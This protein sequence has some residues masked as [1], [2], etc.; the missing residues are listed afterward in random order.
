MNKFFVFVFLFLFSIFIFSHDK[1]FRFFV[2]NNENN[3]SNSSVNDSLED[4]KGF[5]WFA[6][7]N[8]LNKW[9]GN[10]MTVYKKAN[11]DNSVSGNFINNLIKC[12]HGNI[13]I[14]TMDKGIS[15]YDPIK[16]HFRYYSVENGKLPDDNVTFMTLNKNTNI[17]WIVIKNHGLFYFDKDTD[18]FINVVFLNDINSVA[19]RE[20]EVWLGTNSGIKIYNDGK[21]R[22]FDLLNGYKINDIC[23]ECE[24]FYFATD[25]GLFFL[26]NENNEL[27]SILKELYISTL[28]LD[29]K[30]DLWIGTHSSSIYKI[31]M[32]LDFDIITYDLKIEDSIINTNIMSIFQDSSGLMWLGTQGNGVIY[33]DPYV[34]DFKNYTKSIGQLSHNSIAGMLEIDT[35]LIWIG[36]RGGGLDIYDPETLRFFENDEELMSYNV[37]SL[38]QDSKRRVWIGTDK[39]VQIYD[40]D[41]LKNI[42]IIEDLKNY[43][44]WTFYEY[45]EG[46][47]LIGTRYNGLFVYDYDKRELLDNFKFDM[48]LNFNSNTSP[49]FIYNFFK[50][51]KNRLWVGTVG[52]GI[53]LFDIN[54]GFVDIYNSDNSNFLTND[55]VVKID[56]ID[57]GT[58]IIGTYGGGI[59][60]YNPD[61]NEYK[62]YTEKNRL[63]S[64]HVLGFLINGDDIWFST[65]S[66]LSKFNIKDEI[67]IN[68]DSTNGILNEQFF[69]KSYLKDSN[70][71]FYF[72]GDHGLTVFDPNNII[73]EDYD[74]NVVLT[75]I[76]IFN[77][78]IFPGIPYDNHIFL[79][80][81]IYYTDYIELPEKY[82]MISFE[83]SSL[84]FLSQNVYSYKMEGFDKNW[85]YSGNRNMA[86]YTNLNPGSYTFRVRGTDRYGSWSNREVILKV[87][88]I[89]P[90]YKTIWFYL[91]MISLIAFFV[92]LFIEW[93]IFKVKKYNDELEEKVMEKTIE[94]R[95]NNDKLVQLN[96][97]LKDFAYIVSHDLKAPLRGIG[98]IAQWII[99]DYHESLN[100]D[101]KELLDLLYN[102]TERM[103]TLIEG[104]LSYSRVGRRVDDIEKVDTNEVVE[105]IRS[106]IYNDEYIEII[107]DNELPIVEVDRTK[108]TQLFQNIISNAVKYNDKDKCV[109]N[110]GCN[111]KPD[112]DVFYIKDNGPGID[113]KY[114][115]K[116]FKIFQTLSS[117]EDSDSTG[118][119]LAIVKKI[120]DSF[121][122]KIWV[123]SQ[124]GKGTVFY[125]SIKNNKKK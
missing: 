21:I 119:G 46:I 42:L 88:I 4:D 36:T 112:Y 106:N 80:N 11:G 32:H 89:P 64:D 59:S 101:G 120:I 108:I 62:V 38:M 67:F 70:G 15:V 104:I 50:D 39:G 53:Y 100:D 35:G 107:I 109:I 113:E 103:N 76:Y 3:M 57:D 123:E 43:D 87:K 20:D 102:R 54:N 85:I 117:K 7:N 90:F 12:S 82:N 30:K 99:T 10:K 27:K 34:E 55:Y 19:F 97:E 71:I 121:N 28:F 124:L 73:P 51:S 118:I 1:F 18:S 91:L 116:I 81:S 115:E 23:I 72:G 22:N 49:N 84:N 45:S 93:R 68:Y 41:S 125:F 78:R 65:N 95:N 29:S 6:T 63:L 111:S 69:G 98:Q 8:G 83:F 66:G 47:Y 25:K 56:E 79:E 86:V 26:D 77:E 96:D 60:F 13:W 58:L 74:S 110:I 17:L 52:G 40:P 48:Y 24:H 14:S 92:F 61:N 105:D 2:L 31:D 114:H 37:W 75:D 44:V 122:G 33:F 16:D 94:L 5:M 9:D